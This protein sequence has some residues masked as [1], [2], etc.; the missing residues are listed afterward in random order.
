MSQNYRMS[1]CAPAYALLIVVIAI[2]VVLA[3][4]VVVL[5]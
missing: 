2:A 1:D 5:S 3:T 4:I